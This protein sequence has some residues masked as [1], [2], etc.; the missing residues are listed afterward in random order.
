MSTNP[1]KVPADA[2]LRGE[3]PKFTCPTC[4]KT[5]FARQRELI[6]HALPCKRGELD[7]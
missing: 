2:Y 1:N 6:E 5:D 7:D 3:A 4:G